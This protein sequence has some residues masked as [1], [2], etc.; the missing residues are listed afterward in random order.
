M[1]YIRLHKNENWP[2]YDSFWRDQKKQFFLPSHNRPDST[3]WN[4]KTLIL[5]RIARRFECTIPDLMK[6]KT[7]RVMTKKINILP[8]HI[9]PDNTTWKLKTLFLCRI[10]RRFECTILYCIEIKT[11]R[12]MIVFVETKKSNFFHRHISVLITRPRIWRR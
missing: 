5:C 2:S 10:A 6:K 7:D 8:S 4:S 1:H 9:R 3:N 11:D 12:V